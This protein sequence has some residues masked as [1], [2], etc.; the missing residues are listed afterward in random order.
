MKKKN[1]MY[2][3]KDSRIDYGVILPVLLLAFMSIAT[4][5]STTYLISGNTSLRMV[6]M[7]VVWYMVGV[8]AIVVI[9]QFDSEQLWKLTTWGYILGLI[10]LLA[11]LFFYDR[12]T[13]ADTGAKS[14]FRFGT[15]SF[16]P[17][18]VVKIFYI[19]ILAK[20][21][22]SHNMKTKYKTNQTDWQLFVKLILWAAP[23]LVLVILQNDLGTT[24]VFLM[25][26]GGVLIMSGI[27]WK[28][29]LPII[30]VVA[31]IGALLIY[32]VVYNRQILLNI[33]FKNYQFAR[34]DSWL[35]PY[36][37]QGGNGYQLFQS[38]KAIG[39]G[40]MLGKG[41]G[42]SD[43]YVPV[44]ESDLIFATIGEN[45]GFLGGTFLIA[46]YFILIYQMI[47]V[48]FDTKNEFYTYIATGVI[49]MIL[50]H[51]VENIG[52]TIGL[53][54]LT[55]IPLPFISQGG[56][57]LLGNMM[58]IGLIMSMRYHFKSTIFEDEDA[59]FG[60]N[61]QDATMLRLRQEDGK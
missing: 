46:V 12:A 31:L 32:L 44:R 47:R 58:G 43:V 59:A 52:M 16:Q 22:T 60:A 61:Q 18:E 14:W 48:C 36:G 26:L 25:I 27:S 29:L 6:L 41:F 49:M 17:S 20:V 13:Y 21:A 23:A 3:D 30:I 28:I 55:G 10:M 7:Q 57:S 45:F 34:I 5:F 8:V 15:F 51:V 54:P 38:L 1:L 56:S 4:L 39:S 11:V 19:L 40:K 2:D 42:V 24:L 35:D 9:M 37:D 50:F 53:L 33:G